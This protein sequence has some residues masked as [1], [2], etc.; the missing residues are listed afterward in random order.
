ME[1]PKLINLITQQ[2][3][4]V[5]KLPLLTPVMVC[6]HEWPWILKILSHAYHMTATNH[7]RFPVKDH[8]LSTSGDALIVR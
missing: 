1:S 6:M 2:S 3:K 8:I 4:H 7:A 5:L